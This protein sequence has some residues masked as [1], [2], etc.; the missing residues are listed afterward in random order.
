MK[1]QLKFLFLLFFS[2]IYWAWAPGLL[3]VQA[4]PSL[5]WK[6]YASFLCGFALAL[7]LQEILGDK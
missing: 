5:A 7:G 2:A 3:E 4:M 6:A 1:H